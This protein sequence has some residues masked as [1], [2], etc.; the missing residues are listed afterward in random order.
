MAIYS[1]VVNG[2]NVIEWIMERYAITIHK[3]SGVTNDSNLWVAEH[4][5]P[6][7]ILDLLLSVIRLSVGSVE[8][9]NNLPKITF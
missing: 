4:S 2:K 3:E 7:Y 6:R 9:K 5:S 8:I 1:Y